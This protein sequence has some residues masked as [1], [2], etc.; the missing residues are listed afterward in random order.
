MT[1][2]SGLSAGELRRALEA[3][4]ASW[5]LDPEV[6]DDARPPAFPLGGEVP[7]EA[8]RSDE[9]EPI[10]FRA[11]LR[12]NPPADPELARVCLDLGLL[13]PDDAPS[14]ERHRPNREPASDQPSSAETQTD[15]IAPPVFGEG[16]G[17]VEPR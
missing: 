16:H 10:D 4:S 14:V 13:G 17:R 9:V 12:E 6:D 8:P 15:D 1:E 11:L 3:S 7:R 2:N 5:S